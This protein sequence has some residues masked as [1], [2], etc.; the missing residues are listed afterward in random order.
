VGPVL[1]SGLGAGQIAEAGGRL[2][3]EVHPV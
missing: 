3:G 1:P 2:V